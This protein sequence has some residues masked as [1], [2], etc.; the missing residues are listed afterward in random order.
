MIRPPTIS[1]RTDKLFPYTTP[2]RSRQPPA[3]TRD[4][5]RRRRIWNE[6]AVEDDQPGDSFRSQAGIK[7]D[8]LRTHA[9]TGEPDR[10]GVAGVVLHERIEEIGRAS[11]RERVCQ[12]V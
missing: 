2:V 1:T 7:A 4:R 8:D 9:V 10:R 12:Y 5:L 11:C 6:Q 3:I